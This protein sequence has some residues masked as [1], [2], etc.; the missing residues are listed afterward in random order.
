MAA[1]RRQKEPRRLMKTARPFPDNTL[2]KLSLR[3]DRSDQHSIHGPVPTVVAAASDW[4]L[5]RRP[6]TLPIP[7]SRH[8]VGNPP[9]QGGLASPSL[10]WPADTDGQPQPRV[11]QGENPHESRSRYRPQ[12]EPTPTDDYGKTRQDATA[13]GPRLG[14]LPD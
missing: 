7:Q 9:P 12:N 5:D 2:P 10:A 3:A 14:W 1:V 8:P 6:P 13:G 11:F 4:P